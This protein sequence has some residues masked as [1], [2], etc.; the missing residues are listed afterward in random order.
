MPP[1]QFSYVDA[2]GQPLGVVQLSFLRLLSISARQNFT[3]HCRHS[4]AWHSPGS[5]ALGGYQRALRFRGANEDELSYDNS[6]YVK[7]VVD[8]CAARKASGK[9]VLE[10]N[11]PQVEH[12]PLLDVHLTDFGEPGQGFG[13]EVGAACFL[14]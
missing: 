9:T 13:F 8:G 7:A 5:P 6:P 4:A 14:G 10:V 2:A 11:T 12:L 3:Y 1:P